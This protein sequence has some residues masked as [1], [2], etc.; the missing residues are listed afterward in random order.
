MRTKFLPVMLAVFLAVTACADGESSPPPEE[1]TTM[2]QPG[3]TLDQ[4]VLGLESALAGV[5]TVLHEHIPPQAWEQRREGTRRGCDA[6]GHGRFSGPQFVAPGEQ[7]PAQAWPR[8]ERALAEKGFHST[9]TVPLE[10]GNAFVHFTN[11]FGDRI[12]VSSI[13]ADERGGGGS[14]YLGKTACHQGYVRD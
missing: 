13:A 14:G 2:T 11:E 8:I 6:R 3:P 10:A 1:E 5:E 9:S 7:L 12:T 4:T